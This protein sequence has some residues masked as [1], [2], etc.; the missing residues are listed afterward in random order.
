MAPQITTFD[1]GQ[2]SSDHVDSQIADRIHQYL[3]IG[4]IST[5]LQELPSPA[6]VMQNLVNL[7]KKMT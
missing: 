7:K 5:C 1:S 3:Y 4:Q 2:D 6:L